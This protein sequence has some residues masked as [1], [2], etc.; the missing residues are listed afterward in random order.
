M[1]QSAMTPAEWGAGTTTAVVY[2]ASNHDAQVARLLSKG[3]HV[4]TQTN[5]MTQLAKGHRPNH[6]FHLILSLVTF[7]AWLPVWI[8]VALASGEKRKVI[9]R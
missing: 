4:E 8:I 9:A 3:Y 6:I 5:A 1:T 7:G 2:D